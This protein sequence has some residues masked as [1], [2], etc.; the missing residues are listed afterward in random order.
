[1]HYGDLTFHHAITAPSTPQNAAPFKIG[2]KNPKKNVSNINV[3]PVAFPASDP[4]PFI[5]E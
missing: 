4:V 1:M 5:V 2:S 3:K